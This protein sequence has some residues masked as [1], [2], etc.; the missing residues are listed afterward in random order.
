MTSLEVGG[1][2]VKG[3]DA[4]ERAAAIEGEPARRWV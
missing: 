2:V 4:A 1:R 3:V